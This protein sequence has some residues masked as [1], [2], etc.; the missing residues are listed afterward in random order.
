MADEAVERAAQAKKGCP[1]LNTD[2]A[3]F[4]LGLSRR[5]LQTMRADG[6]GPDFRRH[7]QQVRYHIDDLDRWSKGHSTGRSADA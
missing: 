7:G 1:F 2:Q 6:S 3:A 5:T 4:Y